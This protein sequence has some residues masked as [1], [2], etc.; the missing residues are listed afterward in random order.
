V[1]E[2]DFW[3]DM[4]IRIV[5]V[6]PEHEGNV[7][8][9]ARLMKNFELTQLVLVNPQVS[10]GSEAY[11]RA[12]HASDLLESCSIVQN[13]QQ[14][15]L[16]IEWVIGT[17]AISAKKSSNLRRTTI[18]PEELAKQSSFQKGDLAI[19]FGRE[20]HGLSNKELDLCDVVVSIPSSSQYQTLNIASA[21]AIVF[22]ELW[23]ERRSHGSKGPTR[24]VDT[25]T[26]LRLLQFFTELVEKENLPAHRKRLA[27]K[28]FRNIISRAF[29]S[30][31]EAHLLLGVLRRA[32]EL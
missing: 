22:Y 17:T 23:K 11:T 19:L 5:L 26:K 25:H 15:C 8:S 7:G 10:L 24:E 4:N 9:I 31:R 21:S 2:Q 6:E 14:A 20:G 13:L 29:I 28:A 27:T 32:V 12:V 1:Q 30:Q 3:A 16:D 18:S